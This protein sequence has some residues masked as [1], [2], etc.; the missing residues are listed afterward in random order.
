M[1]E[2][3][4]H[5]RLPLPS[6]GGPHRPSSLS[7]C[8]QRCVAQR[9]SARSGARGAGAAGHWRGAGLVA[10]AGH[11]FFLRPGRGPC[12]PVAG[13]TAGPRGGAWRRAGRGGRSLAGGGGGL[14][15]PS[16]EPLGCGPHPSRSSPT[17]NMVDS[18]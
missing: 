18:V 4:L 11:A 14:S 1:R 15:A 2:D 5:F 17:P 13:L 10:R 9:E 7:A 12:A 3:A 8:A 16:Q 6:A